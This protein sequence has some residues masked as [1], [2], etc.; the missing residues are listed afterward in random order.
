MNTQAFGST[1]SSKK[2]QL[3]C[4]LVIDDDVEVATTLYLLLNSE[5][6]IVSKFISGREAL[7]DVSLTVPDIILLD[8]MLPGENV[9]DLIPRFRRKAGSDI[10]IIL[11]SA[12]FDAA[13]AARKLPVQRFLAKPFS[14]EELIRAIHSIVEP[15]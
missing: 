5:G 6:Y 7:A 10:P 11:M 8:Y 1:I 2:V 15:I 12:S 3:T 4:I 9:D 14:R 13:H